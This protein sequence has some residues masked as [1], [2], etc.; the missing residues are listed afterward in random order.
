[1]SSSKKCDKTSAAFDSLLQLIFHF[2][3]KAATKSFTRTWHFRWNVGLDLD[4][5][6][7][8]RMI[9]VLENVRIIKRKNSEAAS[10]GTV[11]HLQT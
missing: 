7:V 1:M 5:F 6:E 4:T 3:Y 11:V 10:K 8:F 2:Q 9:Y